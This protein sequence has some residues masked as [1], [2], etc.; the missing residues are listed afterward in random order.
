MEGPWLISYVVLWVLVLGMAA[1][2]LA[3]SRLLGVLHHRFGPASAKQLADG[4]EIGASVREVEARGFDQVAWKW[5]SPAERDLLIVFISPQCQTCDRL[6]P[7]VIDYARNHRDVQVALFSTLEDPRMNEAFIAYR[8]LAGLVYVNGIE[9]A[10]EFQIEGTPYAVW[11]DREGVVRAKGLVNHYEHL[12]S[13]SFQA[14]LFSGPLVSA[15]E[16]A[17][18]VAG[19]AHSE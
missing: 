19:L 15:A 12:E 16:P 10:D 6:A 7:H 5:Q 2:I 4:P 13:L 18:P 3:H 9:L 17:K 1:A 11:I 8:K 14:R